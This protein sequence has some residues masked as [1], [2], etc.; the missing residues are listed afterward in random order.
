M[1][2]RIIRGVGGFYDIES[3][4]GIFRTRGRGKFRKDKITPLVGDL[5]R[6]RVLPDGDG[7]IDRIYPRTSEFL[8]PPI[9]NVNT[10]VIVFSPHNPDPNFYVI[11]RF[12][13]MAEAKG[14]ESV[15]CLNKCDLAEE[16]DISRIRSRFSAYSDFL[17]VSAARGE[18][19]KQLKERLCGKNAALAG[20]S[21]VGKSTI[22]NLLIPKAG[23]KTNSVSEKT[24]RG[25]HTTRHVEIFHLPGGGL[26]YDTP[27]F[28]SLELDLS[29]VS[30]ND[31]RSFYPE[32]RP[33]LGSCRF[34]DCTHRKEPG[35]AV[36]E[37]AESGDIISDRYN[38]YL[39]NY[40]ELAE[41]QKNWNR[42]KI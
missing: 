16:G 17:T 31:L 38:S 42:R 24:A 18:G 34:S 35:C 10:L 36:R 23:M 29:D 39:K 11:D 14:V 26:I 21:G 2:G 33:Y 4:D 19:I 37:A 40:E 30:P 12:L 7:V 20:F 27:G 25:R 5:V 41:K 22:T 8:R 28:M 13:V 32:F 9:S 6:F 1:E 3:E 15:L